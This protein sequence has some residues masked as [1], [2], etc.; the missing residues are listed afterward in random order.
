[1]KESSTNANN[2]LGSNL[3]FKSSPF[4]LENS[5]GAVRHKSGKSM[6]SVGPLSAV[7]MVPVYEYYFY[8]E[9]GIKSDKIKKYN[10]DKI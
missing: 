2:E 5:L 8:P 3:H 1:M 10:P 4:V 7:Q 6:G 9:Y